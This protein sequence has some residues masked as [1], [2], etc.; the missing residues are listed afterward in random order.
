MDRIASVTT[1]QLKVNTF[2]KTYFKRSASIISLALLFVVFNGC[3]AQ[4]QRKA[5][6]D[7]KAKNS[8]ALTELTSEQKEKIN[9]LF[10]TALSQKNQGNEDAA[11]SNLRKILDIDPKHAASYYEMGLAYSSKNLWSQAE[12]VFDKA[13][14]LEPE[15]EWFLLQK[16]KTKEKLTKFEE[17]E[18]I[19][20]KLVK[21][22]PAKVSYL[23]DV[24]SMKL[25]RNELKDAIKV[26]DQIEKKIGLNADVII[27]KEKIWLKLNNVEK[28]AEEIQKLIKDS[29]QEPRYRILL[30]DLYMA[31]N[32]QDEAFK[33]L[34][35]LIAIDEQNGFA[36]LSLATYYH[37]K[38]EFD[39]SFEILK[40][41]F[42][43]QSI[44][45]D[46]KVSI[47]APYFNV[48]NDTLK[49]Q[50][51][52][53]LAKIATSTH[54]QEAKAHAIYGDLLYQ[55]QKLEEAKEAYV[56][57]IDLDKKVFAVWQNLMFIEAE[58]N[59]YNGLLKTT[60]EAIEL[61]PTNQLVH[62]LNAVAKSQTKDYEG[63]IV[64]YQMALNLLV[65]N[66]DL[67]AQIYAG[68]GDAY[69]SIKNHNKSDAS[70]DQALKLR[71]DDP[72]V[73][74]NYAYY[75]SL[76]NEKLEKALEMSRKSNELQKNNPSFLDTYAWIFYKQGKY[77]D[78]LVWI[79]EA[80][81]KS[82][83][84]SATLLDHLGDILY[85]LGKVDEAVTQW[86][87][88]KSLGDKSELLER[89]IKEKKL[90]EE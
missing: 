22:Y 37:S 54:P 69:H 11:I 45:I 14:E 67:E 74:N 61:Y 31:N 7:K 25:Y 49:A 41:A 50:Q 87:K 42:A 89:K 16:A 68:L 58:L 15:N 23:F 35:E 19:Y 72:Y 3:N 2:S 62:Y 90:Y 9:T 48:M 44:N 38:N 29:P 51:A 64:S 33:A 30:V 59:D 24:A 84:P 88:A 82:K 20:E 27:Q 26:Y 36:Q 75:L 65:N 17:A 4:A 39:K 77:E 73:L 56:K 76:R 1:Q 63:A 83:S 57:T 85:Q 47:L 80:I 18:I 5:E 43:N 28:A 8:K 21:A 60:K 53:V 86:Q 13:A 66:K 46:Q 40:K 34:T 55:T 78:A 52:I 32:M 70:Y 12:L 81:N 71:P 10:F 79:N 6:N